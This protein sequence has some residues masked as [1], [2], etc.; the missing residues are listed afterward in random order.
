MSLQ[1]D[2]ITDP[3]MPGAQPNYSAAFAIEDNRSM[4]LKAWSWLQSHP[5][6]LTERNIIIGNLT[7]LAIWAAGAG[8]VI[9]FVFRKRGK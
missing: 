6:K 4:I 2:P 5:I 1:P 7:N 9:W 3:L 8:L